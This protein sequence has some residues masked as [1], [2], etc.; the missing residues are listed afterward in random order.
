LVGSGPKPRIVMQVLMN[1]DAAPARAERRV[2]ARPSFSTWGMPGSAPRP[3]RDNKSVRNHHHE[4]PVAENRRNLPRAVLGAR[5]ST[6]LPRWQVS[7]LRPHMGGWRSLCSNPLGRHC[8]L[9]PLLRPHPPLLR[10]LR[11]AES[12][13][14][15]RLTV[16]RGGQRSSPPQPQ[17]PAPPHAVP[18]TAYSGRTPVRASALPVLLLTQTQP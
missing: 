4:N 3:M 17:P 16:W 13:L 11:L 9:H 7:L 10:L 1:L 14:P 5:R 6:A 15:N 8:N 12:G 18:C 2:L